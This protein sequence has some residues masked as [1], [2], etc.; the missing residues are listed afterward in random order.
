[1]EWNM[2]KES[3]KLFPHWLDKSDNSNFTKHLK[4]LNNQ[5]LDIRHKLKTLDWC[6]LLNKPIQVHKVQTEPHKWKVEF[7]VNVPRLK[8]VNIYKN[9]TI[10]NNEVVN[11]YKVINGYYYNNEF[12]ENYNKEVSSLSNSELSDED[13]SVSQDEYVVS[14]NFNGLIDKE[15]G[16]YYYDILNKKYYLYDG[17]YVEV[18]DNV[19]PQTSLIYSESYIDNHSHSFR[20]I[21]YEDNTNENN[22]Y[23]YILENTFNITSDNLIKDDKVLLTISEDKNVPVIYYNSINENYYIFKDESFEKIDENRIIFINKLKCNNLNGKLEYYYIDENNNKNIINLNDRIYY[24]FSEADNDC[25]TSKIPLI[26]T[27]TEN[28][29]KNK[30]TDDGKY[31]LTI[32]ENLYYNITDDSYYSYEKD[33]FSKLDNSEIIFLSDEYDLHCEIELDE[34]NEISNTEYYYNNSKLNNNNYYVFF[35][36][37]ETVSPLNVHLIE[38]EDV[39]PII[40]NDKYVVEVITWN[41]Y[42]FLKGFPEIDFID[43]NNN[44]IIDTNERNYD[45]L[46]ITLEKIHNKDYLTFRVHQY[47]IK[48]VEIFKNDKPIHIADFVIEKLG[49]STKQINS[50]FAHIYNYNDNKVYYPF[51]KDTDTLEEV[52]L[53]VDEYVW[54]YEIDENDKIYNEK[55]EFVELKSNYDLKVTYYDSLYPYNSEFDKIISKRYVNEDSIFYHDMSLDMLGVLYNVP[56]HVFRQPKFETQKEQI[57]FYS[58]TYPQYYDKLTEDDYN[59][60]KRLEYYINNYNKIYFPCLELWKYFHIDSELINRKVII[61]EQNYSYMRTLDAEENKYINELGKNKI[62]SVYLDYDSVFETSEN[63]QKPKIKYIIPHEDYV[64]SKN[65]ILV[66]NNYNYIKDIY[67]NLVRIDYKYHIDDDGNYI[68]EYEDS[69]RKFEWYLSK[70]EQDI[71]QIKLTES[72]KVVPNTRYQLRFCLKKYPTKGLN[73]KIIYKNNKGDVREVEEYTPI[74]QDFVDSNEYNNEIIYTD[75]NKEWNIQCEYICTDFLTLS[76]AQNIELVL[77][78]KSDFRISDVT[79]QRITINHFDSEYMKTT[80]DYNSC[81]YDLYADYTK[82]PSNIRYTNLDVFNK[83]L[84]RSLPIS[85]TGFFNLSLN[86]TNMNNNVRLETGVNLYVNNLLDVESGVIS[87]DD[88]LVVNT[89]NSTTNYYEKTFNFNKYI[90]KGEYEI[91]IIPQTG[92]VLSDLHID[93]KMLV[94]NEDNTSEYKIKTFESISDYSNKNIFKIPFLNESVNSFSI[95][96]YRN[97]PI[98]IEKLQIKRKSPLTEKEI[99]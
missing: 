36:Y 99:I 78:S 33:K 24:I 7:N 91:D 59:Y 95:R 3:K 1:M 82:I 31:E 86:N 34:N 87:V 29:H 30:T 8:E 55:G 20:Y 35:S 42:H 67:G 61:A 19:V 71:H 21:L 53:D 90:E 5:Q 38:T 92:E 47:G 25:I 54:R 23:K 46:N 10:S 80:T 4:I 94:F 70:K 18:E 63:L 39:T 98:N 26:E 14:D 74:R 75:Y 77:E 58:K 85:K 50:N 81:V 45:N 16:V 73:L 84:N 32:N 13:M 48:L 69:S 27:I 62:D 37:D 41:D 72:L 76:N 2:L 93:I 60:Q 17:D 49:Y 56:R 65:G 96:F 43:Y 51:E 22:I 6:R 52:N 66:D 12:Y 57:E 11:N 88:S 15:K 89:I 28:T 83:I 68:I 79:L 9:P 40:S 44:N 97:T 64:N